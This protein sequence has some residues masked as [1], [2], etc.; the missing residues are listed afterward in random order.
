MPADFNAAF[1]L[2]PQLQR[3][4]RVDLGLVCSDLD[5]LDR[6]GERLGITLL[7]KRDDAQPLAMGGN[8]VRQLEYYLGPGRQAGADMV[9]ITG[10]VQSNFVRLCAAAARK[11]GWDALVQLEERVEKDDVFYT[12]SGNVL[13]DRLLGAQ[14]H[15][16]AVGE[17]EAAADANLDK[18]ADEQRSMGRTPHVVHLGMD[19]TPTGGLGY[20][21]AA[22]ETWL[23]LDGQGVWPDHVVIPSGS[24]LTHA[25]FLVGARAIGWQVPIHGIC[26]RRPADAQQARIEQRV[27]ELSRMLNGRANLV[28]GDLLVDDAVLSPGYGLL[29]DEVLAAIRIAALDEA[30]LV[31]PVYSGRTLAGLISLVSRGIIRNGETVLFIHTGGLPAIFAYQTDLTEGLKL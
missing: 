11:L 7:A 2:L 15:R 18:L 28:E 4:P 20:A 25:G 22:V 19:H 9:L 27:V 1:K 10:A 21:L 5:R 29:N 26:V 16:F 30:L 3:H 14:I 12:G 23:Q 17:D 24:G 6:L 8:K 13:L 31:D